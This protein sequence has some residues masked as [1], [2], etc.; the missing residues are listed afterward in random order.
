M[1][2]Y[3]SATY[4]IRRLIDWIDMTIKNVLDM[5]QENALD[6]MTQKID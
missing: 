6:D 1:V 3:L 5:T 4:N 2:I